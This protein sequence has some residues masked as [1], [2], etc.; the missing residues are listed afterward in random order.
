[1]ADLYS[2][3]RILPNVNH[4][5]APWIFRFRFSFKVWFV[6]SSIRWDALT[7]VFKTFIMK[8]V[9][10]SLYHNLSSNWQVYS[11]NNESFCI[12]YVG[13]CRFHLLGVVIVS[14]PQDI[15]LLDARRGAE[16]FRKVNV[17][18][19]HLLW[20][21]KGSTFSFNYSVK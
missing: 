7:L 12:L 3:R 15:A 20:Y 18:V 5:K 8:S 16:M 6:I 10:T 17:P 1:M 11:L 13:L 2:E 14:T 21:L 4:N 19:K 9:F